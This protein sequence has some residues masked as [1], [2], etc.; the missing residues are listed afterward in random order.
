MPGGSGIVTDTASRDGKP[1]ILIPGTS[2]GMKVGTAGD[3]PMPIFTI[4]PSRFVIPPAERFIAAPAVA[5]KAAPAN[6]FIAPPTEKSI[7]PPV[8]IDMAPP[9]LIELVPPTLND[10]VPPVLIFV[11]TPERTLIPCVMPGAFSGGVPIGKPS[12]GVK[13]GIAPGHA[14]E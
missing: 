8:L 3:A 9:V 13:E 5:L 2:S 6:K 12:T 10:K 7:T 11:L 1:R 14:Y 4:D